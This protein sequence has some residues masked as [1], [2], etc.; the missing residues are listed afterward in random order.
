MSITLYHGE[1]NGPSLT[2]LA[3]LFEKGVQAELVHIDLAGGQRHA[4]L[5]PRNTETDMSIEGEGPVLVVDGEAMSDSVFIACYLDDIGT[6]ATLRPAAPYA[7]W[8]VMMWC[9]Q[10]IERLAPAA[11]FLGCKAYPPHAHASALEGIR[12]ADLKARWA[13]ILA[14]EFA[15]EQVVDS[16]NKVLQAVEKCEARLEGRDWLFGDFS[17]ADLET[18][19][20]LAGMVALLPDAFANA[21]RTAAW[22]ARVRSREA[23]AR[24]LHVSTVANPEIVWAPGPEI[25]RWG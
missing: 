6:G 7:R 24:A 4:P 10:I 12:S 21:P 19:A 14:G 11:A 16:R 15:D 18:Y 17:L 1:P 20:W 3:A 13:A 22:L 2:V 25:N 5:T 9:R 8:E 23:V